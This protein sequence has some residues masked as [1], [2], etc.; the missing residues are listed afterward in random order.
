MDKRKL[1][2]LQV[3]SLLIF[4]IDTPLTGM[5]L[6]HLLKSAGVDAYISIIISS[7][8]SIILLIMFKLIYNFKPELSLGEKIRYI[9]GEKLGITINLIL[10]LLVRMFA[11]IMYFVLTDF[12]VSQFLPETPSK[13]IG[14]IFASAIIYTTTKGI[15]IISR[16]GFILLIFSIILFAITLLGL[17]PNIDLS[18]LKPVLEYGIGKPFLASLNLILINYVPIFT[19]LSIPKNQVVDNEK[20]NRFLIIMYVLATILMFFT[21]I[22]IVGNMG[23]NLSIIYQYPEYA[24]L[25]RINLFNFLD[26]IENILSMQRIVKM[27]MMICI[28]TYFISNTLDKT[29][30][31]KYI[32]IIVVSTIFISSQIFRTNTHFNTFVTNYL[33]LMRIIFL[34]LII[35]VLIRIIY[36]KRKKITW[37]IYKKVLLCI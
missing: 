27:F 7:I 10:S 30:N 6:T 22:G 1:N 12:I 11:V 28:F 15:E 35:I 32:T 31:K 21:I 26:R 24:V 16:L 8:L 2:S 4:I 13:I 34:A 17:F 20:F 36:L 29:N 3:L 9:F 37:L 19:L 5:N 23:I 25:K 14:I 18:N 33:P